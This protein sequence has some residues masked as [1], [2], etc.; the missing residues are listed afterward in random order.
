MFTMLALLMPDAPDV[1]LESL[2]TTLRALFGR[3]PGFT[4]DYETLPFKKTPN[5]IVRWPG[6][7]VRLFLETGQKAI[8]DALYIAEILREAAPAGIAQSDRRFRVV[9]SDDP[10][11]DFIDHMVE[12]M[13]ML[14]EIEGAVVFDPQQNRL[15]D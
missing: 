3:N 11:E 5:I 12:I 10:E 8:D 2:E 6:W 1:P 13:S 9:F 15:M 7:A 14:E 4:L